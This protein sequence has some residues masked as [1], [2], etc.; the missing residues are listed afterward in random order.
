MEKVKELKKGDFESTFSR[1]MID[2]TAR[3][4]TKLDIG[5]YVKSLDKSKY[6]LGDYRIEKVYRNSE[7][8]YE[9][10]LIPTLQKNA[11]LVIVISLNNK[12]IFGHYLLE[13]NKK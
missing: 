8:T 2:I 13:L 11:Y 1:T 3:F 5:G 7:N 9:Q 10:I 4:E 6:L 12:N